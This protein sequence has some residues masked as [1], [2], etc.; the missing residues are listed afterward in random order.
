M[1]LKTRTPFEAAL[2]TFPHRHRADRRNRGD[3]HTRGTRESG[4][5]SDHRTRDEPNYR[6]AAM[7]GYAVVA[8]DTLG[9]ER[10]FT[11]RSWSWQ[12]REARSGLAGPHRIQ[13][14]RQADSVVMVEDTE[15][16]GRR[17]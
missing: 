11:N 16:L 2:D 12:L 1:K 14:T 15:R 8:D 4:S 17:R 9:R 3:A 7:D 5:T 10:T 13:N 6:R